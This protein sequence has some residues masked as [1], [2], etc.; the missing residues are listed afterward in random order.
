MSF[1]SGARRAPRPTPPPVFFPTPAEHSAWLQAHSSNTA[2]RPIQAPPVGP[3]HTASPR[4]TDGFRHAN[5]ANLVPQRSS[6]QPPT[7]PTNPPPPP[8]LDPTDIGAQIYQNQQQAPMESQRVLEYY[9]S[10]QI[11]NILVVIGS[12]IHKV[13]PQGI[14]ITENGPTPLRTFIPWH[15]VHELRTAPNDPILNYSPTTL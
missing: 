15:R 6:F 13:T 10:P 11:K 5:P 4:S 9:G 3:R 8:T 2:P 14:L 7:N 12:Q 1:L